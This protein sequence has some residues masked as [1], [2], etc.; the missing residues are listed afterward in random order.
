MKLAIG[1]CS[2]FVIAG[3]VG[4][5]YLP[6]F[7]VKVD[8]AAPLETGVTS[9]ADTKMQPDVTP[10]IPIIPNHPQTRDSAEKVRPV[11]Q[12]GPGETQNLK[13]VLALLKNRPSLGTMDYLLFSSQ[14]IINNINA[15]SFVSVEGFP[16]VFALLE[17]H[18]DD[19]DSANRL[20]QLSHLIYDNSTYDVFAEQMACAGKYCLLSFTSGSTSASTFSGLKAFG[21]NAF[22][23]SSE[24]D[25]SGNKIYRMM[26]VALEFNGLTH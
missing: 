23:V 14:G 12:K 24:S 19:L 21:Q 5:L 13:D 15:S 11:V 22:Y 4:W 16:V 3:F 20:E 25:G 17:S 2:A 1:L 6:G 9:A 7:Q 8:N 18:A 10:Q 26:F